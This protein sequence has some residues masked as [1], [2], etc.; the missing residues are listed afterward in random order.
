M[1]GE[2]LVLISHL[3][4]LSWLFILIKHY[5]KEFFNLFLFLNL[6]TVAAFIMLFV[7]RHNTN[8]PMIFFSLLVI[9]ELIKKN[10][11]GIKFKIFFVA[12]SLAVSLFSFI[13]NLPL[14]SMSFLLIICV[15]ITA[16]FIR[17]IILN[18]AY[19]A[20]VNLLHLLL[21]FYFLTVLFKLNNALLGVNLGMFYFVIFEFIHILFGISFCFITEKTKVFRFNPLT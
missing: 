16:L 5:K 15:I 14:T 12:A 6:S 20:E 9:L 13:V 3:S 10:F 21:L 1:S 19:N 7:F 11:P 17:K 18:L 2:Y 8:G 4:A